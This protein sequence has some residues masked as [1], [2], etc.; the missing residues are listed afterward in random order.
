[1][2]QPGQALLCV[3]AFSSCIDLCGGSPLVW[4]VEQNSKVIQQ[5]Q[6][7]WY[8]DDHQ[9]R[10]ISDV[11]VKE[12]KSWAANPFKYIRWLST[13]IEITLKRHSAFTCDICKLLVTFVRI[14]FNQGK[15]H[16]E[17][18]DFITKTCVTLGIEDV[19]VCEE[20]VKEFQVE[21][22]TVLDDVAL[23]PEE[24]CGLVFG[25]TCGHVYNPLGN[26]SIP[27]PIV[28]KP[29]VMPPHLPKPGSPKLRV[30]HLS[31]IH[32]DRLYKEGSNA[33]C[34]EPLCCRA[35]DGPPGRT[36]SAAG[37]WGDYRHCDIPLVT[38]ENLF[39]HLNKT[40]HQFDYILWTGDLPAH[41]VWNQT[42]EDQ[43]GLVKTLTELFVKY[44]PNIPIYP[45]LGNHESSP[46]NSFPP[47]FITGENSI[48]WLYTAL[49]D[50][51]KT[52]LPPETTLT[53]KNGAFYTVSPYPGFRIVSINTNYCNNYNWWLLLNTTDPA[54]ELSWLVGV[55]QAAENN[56]E[57]VHIIGHIP[58]GLNDCLKAWSWNY[59]RIINRYESTVVGQFFGHTHR[60]HYQMFYD[61]A[62]LKR[63]LS[64]GYIV[65]SVTTYPDLN[66]GYRIYE[67]DG[68]YPDSSWAVLDHTNY[69]LNL[70]E[71]NINPTTTPQ[72]QQLYSAKAAYG[73]ASLFPSDWNNLIGQL[74]SNDTLFQQFYRY[75]KKAHLTEGEC[76]EKCKKKILCGLRTGRSHD[77]NLCKG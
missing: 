71:A 61:V 27:L 7:L 5:N 64:V 30:L 70:T 59:Y 48:S 21:V 9:E 42:R 54:G 55:L 46:V 8:S 14:A 32:Y 43:L 76:D 25:E 67:I 19:R 1:M 33:D 75:Y 65:G 44:L 4:K 36:V 50:S 56:K 51:W 53:I 77:P 58:P 12:S 57:K 2:V 35:D 45:A 11:E 40:R 23:D 18:V 62:D 38:L 52:W 39:S 41:D 29:P 31:D 10:N 20:I 28:P 68:N 72:W 3:V 49:A 17:V 74:S 26:W 66:P 34:D 22:L 69:I 6:P 73:M 24:L 16:Q 60:D 47:P 37:K 15:S 13:T 63:P